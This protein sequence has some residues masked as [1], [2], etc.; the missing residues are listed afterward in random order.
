MSEAI[1]SAFSTAFASVQADVNTILVAAVPIAAAI[2]GT[3]FVSRSAFKWFK[4]MSK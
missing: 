2:A 3:L 1:V 4:S